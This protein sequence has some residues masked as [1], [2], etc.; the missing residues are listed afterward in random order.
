M[1]KPVLY[2]ATLYNILEM[3]DHFLTDQNDA[4]KKIIFNKFW[5]KMIDQFSLWVKIYFLSLI[6]SLFLTVVQT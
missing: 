1:K 5:I 3:I 2:P 4:E 6:I